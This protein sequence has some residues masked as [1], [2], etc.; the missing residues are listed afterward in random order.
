MSVSFDVSPTEVVLIMKI[1][2]RAGVMAAN[3]QTDIG[4]PIDVEMDIAATHAN[5]CALRLSDLLAASDFDFAHDIFGI[6]RHL[7]RATGQLGGCFV[8]RY[9]VHQS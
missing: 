4:G 3:A 1:A 2:D 6:V 8:P 9:A 5:G 7:N